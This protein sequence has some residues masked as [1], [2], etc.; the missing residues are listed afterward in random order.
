MTTAL[1][2]ERNKIAWEAQEGPQRLFIE[3][4][5]FE[6]MYGGAIGGGKTDALLGDF[7]A[8]MNAGSAWRGVYFRRFFP[9]M[10]DVIHRSME[11]FGP[12]YGEKCYSA[13]RHQW[14][15]PNG[16]VLQFRALE[17]DM[18]VYKFQGQQYCLEGT[19]LIKMGDGTEKQIKDVKTGESVMTLEGPQVVLETHGPFVK[20]CVEAVVYDSD[21]EYVGSQVHPL[22]HR[23]MTSDGSWGSYASLKDDPSYDTGSNDQPQVSRMPRQLSVPV[24]LHEPDLRKGWSGTD[25]PTQCRSGDISFGLSRETSQRP[26]GQLTDQQR[27]SAHDLQPL[28]CGTSLHAGDISC[29]MTDLEKAG[30]YQ[31]GLASFA[32]NANSDD[33]QDAIDAF[34]VTINQMKA[35][36]C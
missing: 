13:S 5:A 1:K 12:V 14:N 11:I 32:V 7:A 24:A 35:R 27:P 15:F 18:D 36:A 17:K 34:L 33:A 9:D 19:S 10:D 23:I 6:C 2:D 20:E 28:G 4:P 21:G 29:G 26:S 3:C 22:D 8:G 25:S 30:E 16:A 31:G